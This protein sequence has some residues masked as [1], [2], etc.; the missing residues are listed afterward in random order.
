MKTDI[1]ILSFLA[2]FFLEWEMFQAN[3]L[4]KIKTHFMS[5]GFHFENRAI[6]TIV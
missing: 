3:F 5:N 6:D 4:E 2:K 1:H